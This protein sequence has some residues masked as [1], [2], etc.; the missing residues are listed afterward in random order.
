MRLS[1]GLIS[2]V[3][4]IVLSG[5]APRPHPQSQSQ[6]QSHRQSHPTSTPVT[7]HLSATEV[8][9]L[10]QASRFSEL[11]RDFAARQRE[12][13]QGSLNEEQL[14]DGFRAFYPTDP[15]LAPKFDSWVEQFPSSYVAHLARA[16]YYKKVGAEQRGADYADKTTSEQFHNME[17]AMKKSAQDLQ[18]S[19]TLDP[20]P[21]LS[22]VHAID[23]ATFLGVP[24]GGRSFLVRAIAL[25]PGALLVRSKYMES[26]QSRWGGS[27]EQMQAFLE[28]CRKAPLSKSGLDLLASMVAEDRIW[29]HVHGDGDMAAAMLDYQTAKSLNPNICQ[30]CTLE[31]MAGV[32][33]EQGKYG[34]AIAVLSD[35]LKIK[36]SDDY[37]L[38]SRGAAYMR[39]G[40]VSEG[41]SDWKRGADVGSAYSQVQLGDLYMIGLPGVLERNTD[42]A[43]ELFRKAAAQGDAG[44]IESLQRAQESLA[45]MRPASQAGAL[46]PAH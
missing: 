37:A 2:T 26:L 15:Q 21:M 25:D 36:P 13:D 6:F 44:G 24:D 31:E 20:K 27:P 34:E 40:R 41:V 46:A 33:M 43:I 45:H 11:D 12:Y 3:A 16:I 17:V 10:L 35:I 29:S 7:A 32:L 39:I 9:A 30:A 23:I 8:Q 42:L 18:L 19:L 22:F 4:L 38:S 28:D 5:C 14:R 1:L